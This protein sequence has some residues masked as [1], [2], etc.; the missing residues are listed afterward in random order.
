[1][2]LENDFFRNKTSLPESISVNVGQTLRPE[3][4]P[5]RR[6]RNHLPGK[7][8]P[9]LEPRILQ[10]LP[11][12]EPEPNNFFPNSPRK[13]SAEFF[14]AGQD[15]S[16]LLSLGELQPPQVLEVSSD[17]RFERFPAVAETEDGIQAQPRKIEAGKKTI[18][19]E[20]KDL[21]DSI[22]ENQV[23]VIFI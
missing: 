13:P 18:F 1:M 7:P 17:E 12:P 19:D 16:D 2:K 5:K 23:S 11:E 10:Q 14:R 20:L 9:S 15:D 21:D 6:D 3:N 22:F 8:Q 4:R